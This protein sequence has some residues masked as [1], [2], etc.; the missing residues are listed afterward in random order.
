VVSTGKYSLSRDLSLPKD[1]ATDA[2][3]YTFTYTGNRQTEDG[4]YAFDVL[5]EQGAKRTSL[6]PVMF[7]AGEQGVMR[8]P[9]IATSLLRDIY[10]SPVALNEAKSGDVQSYTLLRGDSI[11]IGGVTARF[12]KFEMGQHEYHPSTS[13]LMDA[14][15]RL[16]SMNVGMGQGSSTVT[17]EV[18]HPGATGETGESLIVEASVKPFVSLLWAGTLVMFAGFLFS[19]IRR[20][21]EEA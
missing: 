3:G 18:E 14:A 7:Q 21:R 2:L 1:T 9:D 5:V 13:R 4:K 16:V 12:V 10:L 17:V 11:R 20:S 8:N 15:V 6:A 19:V